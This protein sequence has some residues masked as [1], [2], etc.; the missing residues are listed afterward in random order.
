MVQFVIGVT[1]S[2]HGENA[3]RIEISVPPLLSKICYEVMKRSSQCCVSQECCRLCS[4]AGVSAGRGLMTGTE[5]G[6]AT[7]ER[8]AS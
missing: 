8:H 6:P 7:K 5:A 3:G 4:R 1:Y 2:A